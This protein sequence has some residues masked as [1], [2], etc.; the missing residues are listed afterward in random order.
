MKTT[1]EVSDAL[2]AEA[3]LVAHES[4]TTLRALVEAGLRH[5]L[6]RRRAGPSFT[7]RDATFEGKG[8]QPG[9]EDASWER[10]RD[11]AYEGRGA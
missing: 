5:E 9:F 2:L 4:R 1:I 11:A 6:A 10:L 3:K 7:L 8:L